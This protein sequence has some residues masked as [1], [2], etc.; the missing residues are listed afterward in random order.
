MRF[1]L[2]AVT[3]LTITASARADKPKHVVYSS[4]DKH[5]EIIA[6]WYDATG[7]GGYL[8][9]LK[10][11]STGKT[12]FKFSKNDGL[13][14]RFDA[15]WSPDGKYA[16]LNWY[17]GRIAQ[18][19]GIIDISGKEPVYHALHEFLPNDGLPNFIITA[20]P[21]F[22]NTDL[23]VEASLPLFIA[24]KPGSDTDYDLIVRFED[25]KGTVIKSTG[26]H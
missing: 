19:V 2:I 6:N 8:I 3:L 21:W 18:G 12:Y 5:W 20:G 23:A 25:H 7:T 11:N 17:Y 16:A 10:D 24:H 26:T 22:N 4:P 15:V 14:T 13:P 9:E 1:L